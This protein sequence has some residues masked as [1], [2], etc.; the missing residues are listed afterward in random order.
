MQKMRKASFVAIAA[1]IVGVIGFAIY[2]FIR[3]A[4]DS[5]PSAQLEIPA[6]TAAPPSEAIAPSTQPV[7]AAVATP[8][9]PPI[10]ESDEKPAAAKENH[11]KPST[12]KAKP[13]S[14][15]ED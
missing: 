2:Y 5:P 8:A 6:P 10:A 3:V 11:A 12:K 13:K 9:A 1:V 4:P 14:K 7:P 15:H